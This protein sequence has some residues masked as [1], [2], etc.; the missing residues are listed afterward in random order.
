MACATLPSECLLHGRRTPRVAPRK[1]SYH[2]G[3]RHIMEH[4]HEAAV[5][6]IAPGERTV[7]ESLQTHGLGPFLSQTLYDCARYEE[8]LKRTGI[9]VGLLSRTPFKR[10]GQHAQRR[11]PLLH[12]G[13]N[14]QVAIAPHDALHHLA[15]DIV[16]DRDT[17]LLLHALTLRHAPS[18]G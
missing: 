14:A 17:S 10:A 16:G 18:V 9:D 2:L 5:A 11:L 15:Y 7:K 12:R 4:P 3:R 6:A 13:L 8:F 1:T